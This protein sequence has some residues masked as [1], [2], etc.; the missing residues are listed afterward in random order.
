MYVRKVRGQNKVKVYLTPTQIAV[1]KKHGIPLD[2]YVKQLLEVFAKKRRWKWF[3]K[4]K[5]T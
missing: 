1:V 2:V 4:E 3:K 5:N